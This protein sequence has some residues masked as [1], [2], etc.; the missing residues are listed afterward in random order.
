MLYRDSEF[1]SAIY[2]RDRSQFFE[3]YGPYDECT[4]RTRI[5]VARDLGYDRL[6][7]N[8]VAESAA[9]FLSVLDLLHHEYNDCIEEEYSS[10]DRILSTA[11]CLVYLGYPR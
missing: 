11:Q 2:A 5:S 4:G 9:W 6:D 8:R 1:W 3:Q 7:G 10:N